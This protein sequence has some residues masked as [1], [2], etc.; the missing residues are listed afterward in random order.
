[1]IF[2]VG[3]GPGV[4]LSSLQMGRPSEM[5]NL[6]NFSEMTPF[7]VEVRL[8][9]SFF[10]GWSTFL[11]T[12]ADKWFYSSVVYCVLLGPCFLCFQRNI[13]FCL[14]PALEGGAGLV[15]IRLVPNCEAPVLTSVRQG[16][17]PS[18]FH[19]VQYKYITQCKY[20]KEQ[21]HYH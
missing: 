6:F 1:M 5:D 15:C 20:K 11:S 10:L 4:D 2:W 7:S 21:T 3:A 8:G 9:L 14:A 12:V 18:S 17:K 13:M 16:K 19:G